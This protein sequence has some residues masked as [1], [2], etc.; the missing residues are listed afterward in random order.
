[1]CVCACMRACMHAH[2]LVHLQVCT[3]MFERVQVCVCA[4]ALECMWDHTQLLCWLSALCVV[5]AD[6]TTDTVYTA[7]AQPLRHPLHV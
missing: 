1:M 6:R 4:R 5:T 3:C 2:T 7:K